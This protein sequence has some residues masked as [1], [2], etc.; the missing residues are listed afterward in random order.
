MCVVVS[1]LV[2][3]G[4]TAARAQP[5]AGYIY[6]A[7]GQRG[8]TFE[9]VIGG[10][11]LIGATNVLVSDDAVQ[12]RVIE[13]QRPMPQG[14][15]NDL[16]VQLRTLQQ[17][18]RTASGSGAG[19]TPDAGTNVWTAE[20][21][22]QMQQIRARILKN[23]PNRQGN[24]AIAESVI[25]QVTIASN[26]VATEREVRVRTPAGVSNPLLF[27]IG[28]L[29]ETAEPREK[30]GS[31]ESNFLR[32]L[33]PSAATAAAAASLPRR[34]AI[35]GVVNGQIMPG[36][37]DRYRF[38][39]RAG[40]QIVAI[41]SARRLIPY[42][43]DAVPG[44]FQATA[45]IMDAD[46]RE[47]AYADDFHFDPDPALR[48]VIPNDGEYVL[49]VKDAIYRGRHDFVYRVEIGELPFITSV[50]P[51]GGRMGSETRIELSGWNLATIQQSVQLSESGIQSIE[52]DAGG[53]RRQALPFAVDT[54]EECDE[55]EPNNT[56]ERAQPVART[57][58][59]NGRIGTPGDTDVFRFEGR[60]GDEIVVE[61][62]ARR[63]RSPLDSVLRLVDSSG[64]QIALNDD[65]EDRGDGLNT[66]H[67]DSHLRATLPKSG[68]YYL[69]LGDARRHGG[70]DH[71]YRL[72]I[73]PPRPDFELRVVPSSVALRGGVSVP[74]TVHALRR[75]GF[76]GDISVAL[77]DAPAG[78]SLSGG[79]IPS[80]A[81]RVRMTLTAS[82]SRQGT[83]R[84]S[85]EGRAMISGSEVIRPVVPADDRMQAFAYKH[86][87]PARQM[88]AFVFGRPTAGR[89]GLAEETP[90]RIVRGGTVTVPLRGVAGF[91]DRFRFELSEAPDG[92]CVD[93]VLSNRF[94]ADILLRCDSGKPEPGLR[95]NLIVNLFPL[96]PGG[97]TNAPAARRPAPVGTL[98]AIPFEVAPH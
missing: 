7:G 21:A 12:V 89:I 77:A 16:R 43:A 73:S 81:D 45:S 60:T 34:I 35:P 78:F 90:A 63:L 93:G 50:F 38:E 33:D 82:G 57:V 84:L 41:V 55:I 76:A 25:I 56:P 4:A 95:G 20:D 52:L 5:H 88:F 66:H 31:L 37:V 61:V 91:S 98:P 15:F 92:I 24:P 17:K 14:Q 30:V 51:A 10:Q 36:A 8:T 79:I 53:A 18:R 26:A 32:Q 6:P 67:A 23:T 86:L 87:V 3:A 27:C 75:D 62:Q 1:G 70:A 64:R 19:G 59:V 48:C 22:A 40:Q 83:V 94:G 39:A 72:R 97:N 69:H 28:V 54:L 65:T 58:I 49:M 11:F 13:Y 9:A 44:W 68:A 74:V 29:P 47:I 96:G 80:D 85:L 46:G 2:F 42:L 71:V